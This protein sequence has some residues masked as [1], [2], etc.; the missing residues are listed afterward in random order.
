MARGRARPAAKPREAPSA[1]RERDH[2]GGDRPVPFR[3]RKLSPPSPRVLRPRPRE[4]RTSRSR[5]A[6]PRRGAPRG[7]F[8]LRAGRRLCV[9]RETVFASASRGRERKAPP[10]G[11]CCPGAFRGRRGR[12]GG[13]GCCRR[14][15]IIRK[16]WLT[17]PWPFSLPR[18]GRSTTRIKTQEGP[19]RKM[20]AGPSCVLC[21][22]HLSAAE[23]QSVRALAPCFFFV[24]ALPG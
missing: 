13:E 2:G 18:D 12:R 14:D 22:R 10:R 16:L 4:G 9:P 7:P 19:A 21:L 1:L 6:L 20:R 3:T 11:F 24:C 17:R 8:F 23:K 15:E 5:R